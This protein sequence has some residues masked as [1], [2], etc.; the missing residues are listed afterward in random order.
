MSL[1]YPVARRFRWI[2]N[3]AGSMALGCG[4]AIV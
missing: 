1:A 3:H 4:H 2:R